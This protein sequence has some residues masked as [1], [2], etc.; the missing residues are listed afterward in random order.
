MRPNPS[1]MIRFWLSTITVAFSIGLC[2][3]Q[4]F[5]DRRTQYIDSAL[6]NPNNN[7]I[8]I[9]A[10]EGLTVSQTELDTIYAVMETKTTI[11]FQIVKLIRVM[12]LGGGQYD[13]QIIPQL[14]LVPYWVNHSDTIRGY[15]SENHMIMW[16][17]SDWIMHEYTGRPIDPHLENR[18][19][20]YLQMK[21]DHGFYEFFS[22]TYA[23]YCLS[24]L[25]NLADFAQDQ[26]IQTMAAAAAK[27][28]LSELLLPTNE[29]GVFFPAAGRNYTGKYETPYGQNHNSLIW[30]LTGFGEI[31][32]SSSHA[33]GFLATS[34]LDV[35]EVT[36]SWTSNLD[37]VVT[38]GHTLEEGMVLNQDQFQVD[39]IMFQ[40]SSGGYFHPLVVTE[41][42]Q[43]IVDS[44]L[45]DHVDFGLLAPLAG[46]PVENYQGVSEALDE[47]SMSSVISGQDVAIFKKGR[48]V[49]TSIQDFWK[50]KVGYQQWPVCANVGVT[51]VYTNSG[52]VPTDWSDVNSSNA[53]NHLPYVEQSHNVALV[54]YRPQEVSGILGFTD[55]SVAL[56]WPDTAFDEVIEDGL[57]LIGRQADGYVAARRSCTD[58][59]NGNP[60]CP[61]DGGQTWVIVVGNEDMYGSFSGFQNSVTQSQFTETWNITMNGDSVYYASIAMDSIWIEHYWDPF[62]NTAISE[63][64]EDSDALI[65]WPNPTT[66]FVSVDV[67]DFN[68]GTLIA[69]NS[70]GQIIYSE[71]F[72]QRSGRMEIE[73]SNWPAGL[74]SV[75]LNDEKRRTVGRLI[76]Q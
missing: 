39:R 52:E 15:W 28:L 10:Y 4:T 45:W 8:T 76:K 57:W 11:D 64:S 38:I 62:V 71:P 74:Y 44:N 5:E 73:V 55:K 61:T 59:V 14:N 6:A 66:D 31:P 40:W 69:R 36:T 37:T 75:E 41:S 2:S 30:L 23:P 27:R 42:V 48:V 72:N 19:E 13:A 33:G 17:S 46:Q 54:M 34:T 65:L 70:L 25:L 32:S 24:G 50:G 67:T 16:M 68:N 47:M 43:F 18:L 29:L 12:M 53:N 60:A 1:I 7:S 35:S 9:E 51:A 49:L 3:A 26:E 22:S 20:H 56:H 21:I 63:I 58:E